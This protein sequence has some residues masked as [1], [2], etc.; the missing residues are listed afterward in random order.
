MYVLKEEAREMNE[1]D[2]EDSSTLLIDSS[3]RTIAI[4]RV[5][6]WPQATQQERDKIVVKFLRNIW[7]QRIERPNAGGVSIRSRNGARSRKGFVLNGQL[8]ETSNE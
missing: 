5:G 4:P 1:C 7:K 8:T 6:G 2:M 3:E